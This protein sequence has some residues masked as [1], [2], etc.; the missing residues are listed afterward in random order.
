[1]RPIIA[2]DGWATHSIWEHSSR[3]EELYAR[4][5]AREEQEMTCAAQAAELLAPLVRPGDSLLDA[6]CGSGY[7]YHSIRSRG[8]PVEYHGIDASPTLVRIGRRL[9]PPFGLPADRLRVLRLEDFRGEADHVLCINVLSNMDNFH[10]P[11]ERLAQ[12]ARKSLILRESLA[13]SSEYR[14]VVDRYLDPG[15]ELRVH[16][17]TYAVAEVEAF[18]ASFGFR[19]RRVLDRRSGG[20]PETV[21]DHPHHWTFLV[22]ERAEQ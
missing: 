11:L 4:R 2:E 6:G 9:L 7:F 22:A 17:N 8:I 20:R 21:I 5:C 3:V 10:R 18:I 12:A 19:V 16:V 13:A 1:M 14:Y 15:V